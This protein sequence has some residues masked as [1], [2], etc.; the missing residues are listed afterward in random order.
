MASAEMAREQGLR[1]SKLCVNLKTLLKRYVEGDEEGFVVGIR[2]AHV[3][4]V[5]QGTWGL[6]GERRE[7]A[8][9]LVLVAGCAHVHGTTERTEQRVRVHR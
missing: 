6:A 3:Q 8:T 4:R 7:L 9:G 5:A 1:V 2:V